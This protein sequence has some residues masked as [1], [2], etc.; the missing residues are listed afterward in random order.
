M[1][2]TCLLTLAGDDRPGIMD[3]LAATLLRHGGNWLESRLAHLG[4]QFAGV[5]RFEIDDSRL[6][7]LRH[8]LQHQDVM[9]L[10]VSVKV[11]ET[12]PADTFGRK[13]LVT[14]L[15]LDQPGIVSALVSAFAERQINVEDFRSSTES[16]AMS[17]EL[18][19]RAEASIL[20]PDDQSSESI[21][22]ITETI[23]ASL[24]LDV[25]LADS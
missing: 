2:K 5:V 19:F 18:L 24:D 10:A 11:E 4:S 7:A 12:T 17:G 13:L 16:A 9:E 1:H 8:D 3:T 14:I 22:E 20:V 21:R 15:G 25:D 6:D 23:A